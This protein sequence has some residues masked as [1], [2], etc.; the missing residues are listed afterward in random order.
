MFITKSD[1]K[2]KGMWKFF[3]V[4]EC[5]FHSIYNFIICEGKNLSKI[6]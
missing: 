6:V 3:D 1:M 4:K 2:R 5:G